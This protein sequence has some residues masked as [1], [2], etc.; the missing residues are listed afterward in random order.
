MLCSFFGNTIHTSYYVYVT[1]PERHSVSFTITAPGTGYR[2]N[3]TIQYGETATFAFDSSEYKLKS[4]TNRGK[5]I[6]IRRVTDGE[7]TVY[8]SNL[9][10]GTSDSFLSLP[11]LPEQEQSTHKYIAASY[12]HFA[13]FKSY[14]AMIAQYTDTLLSITPRVNTTIGT[15]FTPAGATTNIALQ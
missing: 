8:G 1:T 10:P 12:S 14:V 5:A 6:I 7:L 9:R 2:A 11:K 3:G 13:S 4:T 15:T